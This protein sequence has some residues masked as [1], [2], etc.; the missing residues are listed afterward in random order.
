MAGSARRRRRR[1]GGGSGGNG[2]SVRPLLMLDG[3][4]VVAIALAAGIGFGLFPAVRMRAVETLGFAWV[5]VGL[6]LAATV[7]GLRYRPRF[8]VGHWRWWVTAASVTAIAVGILSFF[9]PG[10]G[11]WARYSLGGSWGQAVGGAPLALGVAKVVAIAVLTP[12]V[13]SPRRAG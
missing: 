1:G 6:W 3:L 12:V 11:I 9:H 2:G 10:F 7:I 8:V 13:L 4:V 5:P